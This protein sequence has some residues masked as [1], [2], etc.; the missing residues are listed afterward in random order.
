MGYQNLGLLARLVL[1]KEK[2]EHMIILELC[3]CFHLA[4][5]NGSIFRLLC[6]E[7]LATKREGGCKGS[8]RS[9][10]KAKK[11][12]QAGG[13]KNVLWIHMLG[14]GVILGRNARTLGTLRTHW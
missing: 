5:D 2:R 11:K 8:A 13:E 6:K 1:Q 9:M 14:P 12:I 7:A 4:R 10:Q 3:H